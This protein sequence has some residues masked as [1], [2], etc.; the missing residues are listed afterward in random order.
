MKIPAEQIIFCQV[1]IK[2]IMEYI[3]IK[4]KQHPV[5]HVVIDYFN[6]LRKECSNNQ[7]LVEIL[8]EQNE[9]LANRIKK[10]EGDLITFRKACR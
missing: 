7:K 8:L 3:T 10:L 6:N 4:D 2:I 9:V 1:R 5:E